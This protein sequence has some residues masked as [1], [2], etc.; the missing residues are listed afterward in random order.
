MVPIRPTTMSSAGTSVP[1]VSDTG[2]TSEG[3][4]AVHGLNT[5]VT[6]SCTEDV[7]L[8]GA[9]GYHGL[10][11]TRR[12]LAESAKVVLGDRATATVVELLS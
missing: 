10:W 11:N 12:H 4:A 5:T 2:S 8:L 9:E 3:A 1:S 7:P 6:P